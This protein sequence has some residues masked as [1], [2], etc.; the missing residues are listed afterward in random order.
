MNRTVF[1]DRDGVINEKPAD[2]DYVKS[3]AAFHFLPKAPDAI[4]MLGDAG[5]RVVIVSNQRG[6]ARGILTLEQ[7]DA[8]HG[9]MRE[10]LAAHGAAIDDI[11][12][13]PHKAGTCTCRKPGI[14]LFIQAESDAPVDKAHSYMIGDSGNDIAA[15]KKY[16]VKTILIADDDRT[17]FGQDLCYHTLYDAA[18]AIVGGRI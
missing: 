9:K 18:V 2:H 10:A 11:Y 4:R 7:V 16:G 5:Y 8:L 15:G 14:G 17:D 13:C 1:L 6:I 3:W 12:V